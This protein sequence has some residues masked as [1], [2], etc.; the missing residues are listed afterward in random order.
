MDA[1]LQIEKSKQRTKDRSHSSP[2]RIIVDLSIWTLQLL[3][4][5]STLPSLLVSLITACMQV[6]AKKKKPKKLLK[7]KHPNHKAVLDQISERIGQSHK[8]QSTIE[9]TLA[10]DATVASS[11]D[12]VI[13]QGI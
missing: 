8:I 3:L 2:F 11:E 10:G 1:I 6:E 9:H 5:Y 4:P 13:K 12:T 7:Y